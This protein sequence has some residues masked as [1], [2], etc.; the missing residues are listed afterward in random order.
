MKKAVIKYV[1][2]ILPL[3][4]VA[5][6]D[7]ELVKVSKNILIFLS[8]TPIQ[9]SQSLLKNTGFIEQYLYL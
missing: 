2:A 6:G 8:H 3:M 9:P 1:I 7:S 4:M 5:Y